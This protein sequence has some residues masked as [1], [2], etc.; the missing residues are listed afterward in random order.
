MR[1]TFDQL[2]YGSTILLPAL[3]GLQPHQT[4][5]AWQLLLTKAMSFAVDITTAGRIRTGFA[6]GTR[7]ALDACQEAMQV[8]ELSSTRAQTTL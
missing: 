8:T 7:D 4:R 2:Q 6:S 3:C 1:S 5:T